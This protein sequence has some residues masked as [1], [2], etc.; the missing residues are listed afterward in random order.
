LA[1]RDRSIRDRPILTDVYESRND[2]R[3]EAG[4]VYVFGTSPEERSAHGQEWEAGAADVTFV[5]IISQ[6]SDDFEVELKGALRRVSLRSSKQLESLFSGVGRA[7]VYLDITGLAHHVWAPL[8]RAALAIGAAVKAV[9]VEPQDYSFSQLPTEG[10][11]FDLSERISG[12]AP[13]PGFA[14]FREV[15]EDAVCFVPLLG[16]EG[17]RFAYLLEQVQP[18]G[19]KIVP[20]IGVPGFRPEYPFHTYQGNRLKLVET[21]AWKNARYAIANCPFS[22]FYTL[23]DIA[24]DYPGDLLKIAPIGTKPHALGAVLYVLLA[25]P[26]AELVYDH[27]VRKATRT[28]GSA[29]ILV[30]HASSLGFPRA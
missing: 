17:P 14:S 11:I 6:T 24:A 7:A 8:L 27:P 10:E 5:R 9:Y 16:F 2:F 25:R 4:S 22:L 13:I 26:S 30:Y 20:V 3:P 23:Q 19:G 12:I 21:F 18:P 28:V 1:I 29:R 15:P